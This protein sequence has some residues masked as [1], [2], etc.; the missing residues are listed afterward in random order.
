MMG[1]SYVVCSQGRVA[2][3]GSVPVAPRQDPHM[4]L[5]QSRVGTIGVPI[6]V[7]AAV[8]PKPLRPAGV[9]TPGAVVASVILHIRV[10][11]AVE[12][13]GDWI[14]P[15]RIAAAAG[16]ALVAVFASGRTVV[17]PTFRRPHAVEVVG[18]VPAFRFGVAEVSQDVKIAAA[19]A[20]ADEPTNAD[21]VTLGGGRHHLL[22]LSGRIQSSRR[23]IRAA[24]VG[25]LNRDRAGAAQSKKDQKGSRRQGQDCR[26]VP[27]FYH[28]PPVSRFGKKSPGIFL[29]V[30]P[31][32]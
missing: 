1:R 4:V 12:H 2:G 3:V 10:I 13:D 29:P 25:L 21:E 16:A 14:D 19:A 31:P 11:T 23:E 27:H 30:Q 17:Q 9:E 32:S 22:S 26:P 24:G 20:A 7:V 18:V 15:I 6:L 28:S 8:V 5:G